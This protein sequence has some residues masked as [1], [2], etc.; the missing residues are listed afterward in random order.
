LHGVAIKQRYP[1][2]ATQAGYIAAQCGASAYASKY[3]IVVDDDIDVTDLDQLLWAMLTRTDP[4]ESINFIA[5]AWDS[6]ADPRL[7]PE[8]RAARD[9]TTPSLSSMPAGRSIGATNSRPRIHRAPSRAS[10]TGAFRLAARQPRPVLRRASAPRRRRRV[11]FEEGQDAAALLIEMLRPL[12]VK[13][14]LRARQDFRYFET[15]HCRMRLVV[16]R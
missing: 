5:G 4:K 2:H 14:H 16:A 6:P 13:Q 3:V 8:K 12:P 15:D 11:L 7:P 9:M 1:G 10:G